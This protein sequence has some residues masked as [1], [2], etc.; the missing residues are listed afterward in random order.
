MVSLPPTAKVSEMFLLLRVNI[1]CR[2]FKIKLSMFYVPSDPN[3]YSHIFCLHEQTMLEQMYLKKMSILTSFTQKRRSFVT[4]YI[5][6][7]LM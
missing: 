7:N 3:L 4:M 5:K 6:Y 1:L 2:Y